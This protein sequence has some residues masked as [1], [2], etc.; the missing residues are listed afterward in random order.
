MIE[1]LSREGS[2]PEHRDPVHG[3]LNDGR[4]TENKPIAWAASSCNRQTLSSEPSLRCNLLLAV[5]S[6]LSFGLK[7]KE[8]NESSSPATMVK[9]ECGQSTRTGFDCVDV[10]PSFNFKQRNVLAN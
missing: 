5:V 7:Q 8:T 1:A 3:V 9:I 6:S 10:L 4:S 2:V